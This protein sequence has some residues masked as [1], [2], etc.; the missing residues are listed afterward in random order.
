MVSPHSQSTQRS[1][2]S[3]LVGSTLCCSSSG[4]VQDGAGGSLF[5][6]RQ[7]HHLTLVLK[8]PL[9]ALQMCGSFQ[10]IAVPFA[11]QAGEAPESISPGHH[12]HTS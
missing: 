1:E 7:H 11:V 2:I 4:S 9:V 8:S 12:I 5:A 3:H 6:G 10:A